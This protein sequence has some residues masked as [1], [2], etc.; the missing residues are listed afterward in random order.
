MS[1]GVQCQPTYDTL[2]STKRG[3]EL[4]A[5]ILEILNPIRRDENDTVRLLVRQVS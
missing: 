5:R 2:R 3:L 1:Y 4:T